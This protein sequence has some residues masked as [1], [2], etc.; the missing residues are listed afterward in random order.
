V[1]N[2]GRY[3]W[4]QLP[5]DEGVAQLPRDEGGS[6]YDYGYTAV[7]RY[8]SIQCGTSDAGC[9]SHDGCPLLLAGKRDEHVSEVGF[10]RRIFRLLDQ[11]TN[12]EDVAIDAYHIV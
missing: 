2:G 9:S 3:E 11:T 4:W 8:I 1:S 12:P 7:T 5:R 10:I 6:V